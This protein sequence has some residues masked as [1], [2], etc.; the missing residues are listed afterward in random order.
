MHVLCLYLTSRGQRAR[1][2]LIAFW[3]HKYDV[4]CLFLDLTMK[5]KIWGIKGKAFAV[6]PGH[7]FTCS[8]TSAE[9]CLLCQG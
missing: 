6:F 7:V 3:M 8:A 4:G 9:A 1:V 2:Y 5:N